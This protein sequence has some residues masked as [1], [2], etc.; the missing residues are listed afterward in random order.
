M[1]LLLQISADDIAGAHKN[2]ILKSS[3]NLIRAGFSERA[4]GERERGFKNHSLFFLLWPLARK[5]DPQHNSNDRAQA[6]R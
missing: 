1:F 4:K 3:L 5:W 2:S 6:G